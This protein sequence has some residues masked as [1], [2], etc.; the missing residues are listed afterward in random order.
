M[1]AIQSKI[2][3]VNKFTGAAKIVVVDADKAFKALNYY[4]A[5]CNT[6]TARIIP[7]R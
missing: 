7:S 1:E 4:R 6:G 5:L 3:V 2:E